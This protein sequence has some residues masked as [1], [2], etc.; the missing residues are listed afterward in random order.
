MVGL[1]GEKLKFVGA[2]ARF[3]QGF[4]HFLMSNQV[5]TCSWQQGNQEFSGVVTPDRPA[6]SWNFMCQRH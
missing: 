2:F 4:S 1:V 6:V 5:K 3:I